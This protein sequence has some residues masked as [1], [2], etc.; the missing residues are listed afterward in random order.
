MVIVPRAIPFSVTGL[1]Y[2]T[3]PSQRNLPDVHAIL[4]CVEHTVSPGNNGFTRNRKH[5]LA[6]LNELLKCPLNIRSI[7]LGF[8]GTELAIW[9]G[10]RSGII[11]VELGAHAD[12]TLA[13][14]VGFA[15]LPF[16]RD[17]CVE[18]YRIHPTRAYK[19][20]L[21]KQIY[22]GLYGKD[23]SVLYMADGINSRGT[24]V[25]PGIRESPLVAT[26][27][28]LAFDAATEADRVAIKFSHPSVPWDVIV[29][30]DGSTH[31]R[32]CSLE[33]E[34]L[35]ILSTFSICNTPRL[36]AH[37]EL[38]ITTKQVREAAGLTSDRYRVRTILVTQP[39][40]DTTLRKE[41]K[42]GVQMDLP[43][44][45]CVLKDVVTGM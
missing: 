18:F 26:D 1:P 34:A 9:Y 45:V 12:Y 15:S 30:L 4:G 20:T 32:N 35:E 8:H 33:W 3:P 7:V 38:S 14:L 16:R 36:L 11:E 37:D 24:L 27:H 22:Y 44:L 42:N 5:A 41:V 28:V 10:D 25:L 31:S 23:G 2:G 6:K 39:L 13:A 19:I 43:R 21:H 17:P 29:S 40:A